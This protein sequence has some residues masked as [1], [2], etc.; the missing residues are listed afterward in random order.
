M[1][2]V[3]YRAM[4]PLD[5][6]LPVLIH[7]SI[8]T[9]RVKQ[10]DLAKGIGVSRSCLYESLQDVHGMPF[11]RLIAIVKYLGITEEFKKLI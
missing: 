11:D 1:P 3:T 8:K 5:V 2:K 4:I 6:S 9:K 7:G 10:N